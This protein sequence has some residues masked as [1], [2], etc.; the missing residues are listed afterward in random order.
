LGG[1]PLARGEELRFDTPSQWQRWQLPTGAL[2]P[3]GEGIIKAAPVHHRTNAVRDALAFGGGVRGA[4]SNAA[5]GILVMDGDPR[6]SWQPASGAP[7]D[8]WLELDLG[9]VVSTH[10]VRLVFAGEAPPFADFD[11]LLSTGEQVR[12]NTATPVPGTLIYRI[13]ERYGENR[14]HEVVFVPQTPE[15]SLIQVLRL[16]VLRAPPGAGLAEVEVETFGDNLALDLGRRG[17]GIEIVVGLDAKSRDVVPLGNAQGL[18]DGKLYTSWLYG[19][20]IRSPTDVDAHLTLDLGAVYFVDMVRLI[21]A[22]IFYQQYNFEFFDYRFYELLTSD[23][24]LAPDGSLRWEKQF[25]GWPSALQQQQGMADHHFAPV[26][27]RY[28]RLAWRF[29]DA[30]CSG[31]EGAE[32]ARGCAASGLTEELQVFGEGYPREL[33]LRSPVL[34]LGGDQ[35]IEALRWQAHTPPGTRV[36]FRSRTGNELAIQVAWHDKEGKE[37]TQ[38]KWEKLIPSF[39]GSVDTTHVPGGDWSSWSNAYLEPGARFSSP[40]PR[41]YLELEGRLLSATPQAAPA[42]DWLSIA[43][44]PPLAQHVAGELFPVAVTAGQE[45][46]FSYFLKAGGTSTGFDQVAL[47]ASV[48]LRFSAARLGQENFAV[49]ADTTSRGFRVQLPRPLRTGELLELRFTGAVFLDGTRISAFLLDSRRDPLTRQPVEAGDADPDIPSETDVVR[50]RPGQGLL[51]QLELSSRAFSPNGDGI[52]DE[53]ELRFSLLNIL[54]ESPLHIALT[55][56]A[57]RPVRQLRTLA[58]AGPQLFRW[59]GGDEQGRLVPPG[60]YLLRV[61]VEGDART[62]QASRLVAVAY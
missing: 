55:D 59:D 27:A 53:L 14:R 41:R 42:L 24:S 30:N 40:S 46:S 3:L 4:G 11:L 25:T 18:A 45:V 33:R 34:D 47:E 44:S 29:W 6:T 39:R 26:P 37:I 19:R 52:N 35:N 17:G 22:V 61:E 36:E 50:L 38:K 62:P 12:D 56:L 7:A 57:G 15:Q 16:Q 31:P 51:G 13:K 8:S 49:Q 43:Y 10:Q 32:T 1:I 9:R 2:E 54:A 48:P 20:D 23:G 21:S 60:L 5:Q 28:L 58:L